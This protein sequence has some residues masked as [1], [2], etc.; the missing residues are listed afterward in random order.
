LVQQWREL[1][2]AVEARGW[3]IV[4]VYRER[5]SGAG[6]V[7]R[8]EWRRLRADAQLRKFGAV[9]AASLDRLGRS[10]L[11]ILGAVQQF[12]ERGTRLYL[13]REGIAS[14]DAVGSMMLTVLA[15]VAQLERDLIS[16]RTQQGLR[17]AR[18]RGARLGRPVVRIAE[19]DLQRA[20]S[21]KVSKAAL[22]R[23]L[24]VGIST[25]KR[26]L[27]AGPKTDPRKSM[28]P[29]AKTSHEKRAR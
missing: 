14:D 3:V 20:R 9:A 18:T 12:R 10:A 8:P 7:D 13:V 19:R 28:K 21:G 5:R 4:A 11:D 22:A 6:G 26:A 25:V 16:Q 1:R 24:G 17:A 15:G 2:R 29:P 27:D 23:E